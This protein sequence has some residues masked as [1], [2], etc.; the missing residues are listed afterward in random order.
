MKKIFFLAL[1]LSFTVQATIR[2]TKVYEA[3]ATLPLEFRYLVDSIEKGEMTTDTRADFLSNIAHL[4]HIFSFLGQE[5]IFFTVKSEVYKA[6]LK[7]FQGIK[8]QEVWYAPSILTKLESKREKF[9]KLQAPFEAWLTDAIS[10]DL[11]LLYKDPLT[12]SFQLSAKSGTP[13]KETS[14]L[15]IKN[16]FE[17]LWTWYDYLESKDEDEII[18]DLMSFKLTLFSSIREYLQ[19]YLVKT[20]YGVGTPFPK[21]EYL[22]FALKKVNSEN[23]ESGIDQMLEKITQEIV[24]KKEEEEQKNEAGWKPEEDFSPTVKRAQNTYKIP[25]KLPRP[26]NDWKRELADELVAPFPKPAPDYS[27]PKNLPSPTNDWLDQQLE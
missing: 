10:S 23:K 6:I 25:S 14:L 13:I 7:K 4:D 22:F 3:R 16:R 5:E 8:S 26:V 19:M 17:L 20:H 9:K 24:T 2:P 11:R 18:L 21:N 1:L 27:A 12:Q 15:K